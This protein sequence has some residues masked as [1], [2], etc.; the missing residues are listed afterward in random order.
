MKTFEKSITTRALLIIVASALAL[1][2]LSVPLVIAH[3]ATDIASLNILQVQIQPSNSTV[4]DYSTY[5]YNSSGQLVAQAYGSYPV[6]SFGLPSG[7]Y[8]IIAAATKTILPI[9]LFS[10]TSL[11]N[12]TPISANASIKS[13]S[14]IAYKPYEEYGYRL[15]GLNS[16]TNIVIKTSAPSAIPVYK[17]DI[18]ALLP[19]GSPAANAD[20]YASPVATGW[21]YWYAAVNQSEIKMWGQTDA[22]GHVTLAIPELPT[23]ITA[24]LWVPID[25]Q[26]N[27]TTVSINVA[28]QAINVSIY[29]QPQSV[30]FSGNSLIIPPQNS[31]MITLHYQPEQYWIY[32]GAQS[33]SSLTIPGIKQSSSQ[34]GVPASLYQSIQSGQSP[35]SLPSFETVNPSQFVHQTY[36]YWIVIPLSALAAAAVGIALVMKKRK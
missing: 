30:G 7:K 20:V 2:A 31:A 6:Y 16:S 5:V 29:Y 12:I 27:V 36:Y 25:L 4:T 11:A 22:T 10:S 23:L 34:L 24:W 18:S 21:W 8:L 32:Q 3:A 9:S 14:I 28:G 35:S 13:P 19:D 33:S 1:S 26:K 15:I 17:V